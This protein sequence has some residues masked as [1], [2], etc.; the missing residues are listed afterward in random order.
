MN[1][2]AQREQHASAPPLQLAFL[3]APEQPPE[4]R[5]AVMGVLQKHS[6][7]RVSTDGGAHLFVQVVQ[8][9]GGLPFVA[10]YHAPADQRP[11]LERLHAD[12][13]VGVAVLLRGRRI[14][15]TAHHGEQVLQL[16]ECGSVSRIAFA[17]LQPE[18]ST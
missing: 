13:G 12:L 18:S 17:I 6:E 1:A 2:V 14:E 10:V 11:E 16:H 9:H 7:V 3:D 15:L 4:M 8:P 5:L